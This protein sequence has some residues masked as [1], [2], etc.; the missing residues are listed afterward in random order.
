M[1]ALGVRMGALGMR[2]G[3]LG[4]SVM[5]ECHSKRDLRRE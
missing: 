5:H 4:E 2:M 3:A 1:G